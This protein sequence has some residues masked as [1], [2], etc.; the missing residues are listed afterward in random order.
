[1]VDSQKKTKMLFIRADAGGFTGTGHVMRMIALAQAWRRRGRRIRASLSASQDTV[2]DG[3]ESEAS[4]VFICAR[5]PEALEQRLR[6]EGFE[7]VRI[8]AEPGSPEDARATL[9]VVQ[10]SG[11]RSQPSTSSASLR[12]GTGAGGQGAGGRPQVS[13]LSFHPSAS[14]TPIS[15]EAY[16]PYSSDSAA[17]PPSQPWLVTDGYHFDYAYQ[18]AIKASGIS[19]LCTDDHGYSDKWCCDAILNQ[20]LDAEKHLDYNNDVVSYKRLLGSSF[21][22][23]REEFL[24]QKEAPKEWRTIQRLLIT[25]GGSDP[26]NATS[27]TL[28]LLNQSCERALEIRVLAGADNPHVDSL[29]KFNSQH[30]VEVVQNASNMPEQYAW[31]DGIISAGGST[32]WE[33]LYLG[34]PG[35]IVTIADNQLPIVKALTEDRSAALPLG[36][37]NRAGFDAYNTKLAQWLEGPSDVCDAQVALGIIDGGGV[38]R[39]SGALTNVRV[40]VREARL[41]DCDLYLV[42]A[43]DPAVRENSFTPD[44]IEK[45]S[46]EKWFS[47]RIVNADT[48]LLVVYNE[49]EQDVG[50]VRFEYDP[51][52]QGWVIDFSIDS[53]FRGH[54]Y[55]RVAMQ[56]ALYWLRQKRG[57]SQTVLAEVLDL[58]PASKRVFEVIG[59]KKIGKGDQFASYSLAL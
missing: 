37:F 46:H 10:E 5:L 14:Q 55:G 17:A 25:L 59:F 35:A 34:L 39:V 24:Q 36:W 42:W 20:N 40:Q 56:E 8:D 13:S 31:A 58:N 3:E 1:M 9:K 52:K 29:R 33:W 30:S 19:L 16:I 18:K 6:D 50:Q 2:A 11:D 45:T 4:V 47:S 44:L 51:A 48:Y 53:R 28:R 43:N 57:S 32:C 15:S 27:A 12:E 38:Q 49:K 54:G 7:V 41:S 26:E 21:C 22:L 23:F